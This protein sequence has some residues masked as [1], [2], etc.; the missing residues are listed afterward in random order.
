MQ[1]RFHEILSPKFLK[2]TLLEV[3]INVTDN[4]IV[5]HTT[6]FLTVYFS[7]KNHSA[8]PNNGQDDIPRGF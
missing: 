3:C 1:L 7:I 6:A 8:Y 5:P 2:V 4:C